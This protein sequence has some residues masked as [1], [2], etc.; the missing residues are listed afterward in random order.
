M[1]DYYSVQELAEHL[2]VTTRSIRNYLQEGKLHGTKAG[3]KWRFTEQDLYDFLYGVEETNQDQ[4]NKR[5][6]EAPVTLRFSLVTTD[7]YA[8]QKFKD[9]VFTYHLDVYAN[10][11]E[12]LLHYQHLKQNHYELSIG[13]NFNYVMNFSHWIYKLL[14]KQSSITLKKWQVLNKRKYCKKQLLTQI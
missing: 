10:K 8:M 13:G 12:R 7:F 4:E 14:Q 6:F 5:I 1:K 2:S 11:K 9:T 3:G